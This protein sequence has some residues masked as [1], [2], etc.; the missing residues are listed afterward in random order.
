MP[1]A[2]TYILTTASLKLHK[3]N[4][5]TR[6]FAILVLFLA[7]PWLAAQDGDDVGAPSSTTELTR[8]GLSISEPGFSLRL[9]SWVQFRLTYQEE[10]ANG[11]DGTNGRD[12]INFRV[13]NAK[14]SFRGH[15]FEK[16]FQY[17]LTLNWRAGGTS[18]VEHAYF[19]W[20]LM[21]EFNLSVGQSKIDWS[22]E[23]STSATRQTFIDR[24]YISSVFNLSYAKGIWATGQFGE[25]TPYLKYFAGIHNARL[26]SNNDFRP[27]DNASNSDTFLDGRVDLDL[28]YTLRLETHP[29][30]EVR[31]AMYDERGEESPLVAVGIGVNW[32]SGGFTNTN[33]R[34]DTVGTPTGSGRSRTSHDTLA[35]TADVNFRWQGLN[36]H[37]A[38][39]WRHTEFHN[40]GSNRFKPTSPARSG[41][42]DLTDFGA[43]VEASYFVLPGK[44]SIGA[45]WNYL[46]ADEFW[47]NGTQNRQRSILPDAQSVGLAANWLIHGDYLRLSFDMLYVAQQLT[48]GESAGATSLRGAYNSPPVRSGTLGSHPESADYNNLLILRLQLQWK[49]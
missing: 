11:N 43:V 3:E 29:L 19:K 17:R 33:L 1:A 15:I 32:F 22:W 48:F 10:H 28:M 27:R 14:S 21:R 13:R 12:F 20:A 44:V 8:S 31:R 47:G 41:I 26:R 4:A 5:M 49:F 35:V 37:A 42:S 30:G 25:D 39:Y 9:S 7:A 16:E 45:R 40:R 6:F 23:Y 36:V 2:P 46:D 24:G 18:I 34:G 38:I